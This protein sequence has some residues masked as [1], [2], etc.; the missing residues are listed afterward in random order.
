MLSGLAYL[1]AREV[2]LMKVALPHPDVYMALM[3]CVI[4]LGEL[5]K[6]PKQQHWMNVCKESLHGLN[7]DSLA[8]LQVQTGR[9][10]SKRSRWAARCAMQW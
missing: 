1:Q 4:A 10:W 2:K 9:A 6:D 3:G 5:C 8:P 7:E